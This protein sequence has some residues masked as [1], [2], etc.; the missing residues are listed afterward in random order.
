M[1][2]FLCDFLSNVTEFD[3]Y[4]EIVDDDPDYAHPMAG[5]GMNLVKTASAITASL[6]HSAINLKSEQ[7]QI[8]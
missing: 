7:T 5:R 6:K 8:T 1:C 2:D 3:D 4:A